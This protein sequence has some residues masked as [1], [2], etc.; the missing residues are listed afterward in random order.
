MPFEFRRDSIDG[1]IIVEPRAFPD[2]RGFFME[3]YKDSEFARAGIVGPFVQDNHSMSAR[4]VL[5]GLHFQ[6]A[7]HA[8]GKLVRVVA[9]RVWDVAVDLRQ[10]SPT[11]GA[12]RGIELSAENRLQ[13]WIPAGFAHGFVALE[14]GS[15]LLYKCSAEYH[16][17]SESGIRWDD[18]ILGIGWP[19][20]D[21]TISGK[22]SVLPGF[23]PE[24]R[25]F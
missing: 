24:S 4:G 15:E 9:G 22:D 23:D 12:W 25:Y 20:R 1:L 19:L 6:R 13:F 11:F 14:D 18:P 16:G 7:P 21:V 10:G 8:Q 3:T 2:E 5:R 17:P